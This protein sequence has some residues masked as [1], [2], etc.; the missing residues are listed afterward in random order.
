MIAQKQ[1]RMIDYIL[2]KVMMLLFV[3][4]VM[5]AV[6]PDPFDFIF[7]VVELGHIVNMVTGLDT[8]GTALL[9]LA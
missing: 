4:S 9:F 6:F 2:V 3:E 7:A 5:K 8:I 1:D